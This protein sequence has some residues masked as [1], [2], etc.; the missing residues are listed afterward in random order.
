MAPVRGFLLPTWETQREVLA[1]D[2]PW[3]HRVF[4]K[5]C[6]GSTSPTTC[7]GLVFWPASHDGPAWNPDPVTATSDP[8][9]SGAFPDPHRNLSPLSSPW[10]APEGQASFFRILGGRGSVSRK[11][12]DSPEPGPSLPVP[13]NVDTSGAWHR[14]R[15]ATAGAWRQEWRCGAGQ[16]QG[17]PW[18]LRQATTPAGRALGQRCF[19]PVSPGLWI[20]PAETSLPGPTP[21]PQRGRRPPSPAFPARLRT[22]PAEVLLQWA[23]PFMER[24]CR[25]R[26]GALPAAPG[27]AWQDTHLLR[28]QPCPLRPGSELPPAARRWLSRK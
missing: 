18:V 2:Q 16:E 14:P 3:T 15:A 25:Q 27:Q 1:L 23:G 8:E 28:G 10:A 21:T 19:L 17:R 24:G 20:L 11:Q 5:L 7:R 9:G 12:A 22:G 13:G 6:A 26:P 4:P